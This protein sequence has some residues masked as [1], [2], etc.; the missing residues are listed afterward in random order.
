MSLL[1]LPWAP[2]AHGFVLDRLAQLGIGDV[3]EMERDDALLLPDAATQRLDL[4]R[5]G[6]AAGTVVEAGPRGLRTTWDGLRSLRGKAVTIRVYAH[7]VRGG[8]LGDSS[9]YQFIKGSLSPNTRDP[10]VPVRA[11]VT[12]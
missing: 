10:Y 6:G 9:I 8:L 4:R 2:P 11:R 1:L 5:G 7:V 3:L 12:Y